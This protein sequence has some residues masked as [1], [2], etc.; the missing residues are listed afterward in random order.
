MQRNP[1]KN[2]ALSY[3]ENYSIH[4]VVKNLNSKGFSTELQQSIFDASL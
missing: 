4:S 2:K 1:I 3:I